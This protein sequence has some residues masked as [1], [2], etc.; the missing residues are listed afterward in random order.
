M[1]D[2]LTLA[3]FFHLLGAL[4]FVAG[5]VLAG[6]AFESAR[7]RQ[8]PGEIAALLGLSRIGAGLVAIGGLMLPIFG[9]WLVHLGG[10]RFGTGW[11]DWAL[12]L[13]VVA[14]GLGGV[15]GRRPMQARV[16]ATRLASEGTP[17][18]DELRGL[19]DDRASLI[20][21]YAAGS[22]VLVIFA[23]MVFKP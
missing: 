22:V 11:I 5:I 15:G 23:L 2:S 1:I 3:L 14:I 12:L 4:M 16:L 6:V 20:Q 18:T 8:Q 17:M 7:R 21:N 10:F 19:L 13:Y 9:L